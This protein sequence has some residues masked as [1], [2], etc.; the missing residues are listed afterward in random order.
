M[1]SI[2][3]VLA[4]LTFGR[5]QYGTP[6]RVPV[7]PV[8][9]MQGALVYN[10]SVQEYFEM[11]AEKIAA[12][13]V[14]LNEM[15]HGLP[16]AVAGIPNV[17]EDVTGFGVTLE[18]PYPN[19]TPAASRMLLRD[20]A[21]IKGL[22][23]PTPEHSAQLRK[24]RET[25]GLLRSKIGSEKIVLG[26]AIAPFSLPS[27]L[28]GTSKW[29]RLLYTRS[30]REAYLDRL[31]S[32]CQEFV[33]KWANVQL[34]AGAHCVVLADGMASS[35][36]IPRAIFER[37]AAPLIRDTI[38]QING[39]VAYE[40]VGRIEPT[41][42]ACAE[43]GAVAILIGS[44]DDI[45]TCKQKLRGKAALIGNV[46]NMRMR[47]WSAARIETQARTAIRQGAEGYGFILANQGPEIPFDVSP[48]VIGALIEAADKYGQYAEGSRQLAS[49]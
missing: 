41:I 31:L 49:Q 30:L 20:F 24:T 18:Y 33:V 21:E 1:N 46:N 5:G 8:P 42:D 10:C 13:Q 43:L 9:L 38:R 23:C 28:M 3:R 47:R 22:R 34:A 35:T 16:D 14:A 12:A 6:D 26:A 11:P 29:M 32:V 27:M 15:F 2:Q 19:S 44:D 7:F 48:A 40:P 37:F 4:A 45:A 17:I 39:F 36:I 25:I